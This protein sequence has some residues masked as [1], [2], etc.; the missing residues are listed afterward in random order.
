MEAQTYSSTNKKAIKSYELALSY[1]EKHSYSNFFSAITETISI[2]PSFVEAYLVGMQGYMEVNSYDK[3]LEYGEKAFAIAP[4]FFP[5]LSSMLGNIYLKNGNYD[6]ALFYYGYFADKFPAQKSRVEDQ[7][8]R[9]EIAKNL[10][11][12]PV[13]FLPVNL[14]DS[15]N[16]EWDDYWPSIS[17]DGMTLVK[18]TNTPA[19]DN[20]NRFQEDFYISYKT[21]NGRWT[22]AIKMPGLINTPANEGAQSL[23]ADGNG[24]YF[25]ICTSTCHIYYSA[26]TKDGWS[27]PEKLSSPVNSSAS[28]KQPCISSDGKYLFFTSNRSGGYGGYDLYMAVRNDETGEW[29]SAVNLGPT[30]NTSANDVAPF[31]HFDGRTLYFASDGHPGLGGLDIF[32]STR[33]EKGVWSTPRNLGYPINTKGEEQGIIVSPDGRYS[34]MASNREGSRGLD[35]FTFELPDNLKP[36]ATSYVKGFVVDAKT[37][38]PLEAKV[39]L[40]NLATG[41]DDFVTLTK[42]EDGTFFTALPSSNSYAMQIMKKGYLFYSKSFKLDSTKTAQNPLVVRAELQPLT[43]GST[44][45]LSNVYF[46]FNQFTLLPDSYVE[47]DRL[48]LLLQENPTVWIQI[49][50]H[51]D[52]QGNSSYNQKLS[53]LRALSVKE[54]LISRGIDK[55]RLKHVGLGSSKPLSSNDTEEGRQ[56]NRR[57]ELTILYK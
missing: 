29:T 7:M 57:T 23:T 15:V 19:E 48:V 50:G 44:I 6:K 46:G 24:M 25:T 56:M 47:L 52:N 41:T 35:I 31:I 16:T 51:T 18:T 53:E 54:Y 40:G 9:A 36:A 20:P 27:E 43:V 12:N 38:R 2:D 17:G 10:M 4:S 21:S 28:D 11:A 45:V 5:S 49:S 30:I 39:L 26:L 22:K 33:N 8:S 37:K 34:F 14:G 32:S 13:P 3:A 55:F 1:F 42:K